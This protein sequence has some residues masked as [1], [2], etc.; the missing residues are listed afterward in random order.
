M[1]PDT[2]TTQRPRVTKESKE[3]QAAE[4]SH[5]CGQAEQNRREEQAVGLGQ[6][7]LLSA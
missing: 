1:T 3:S 2:E 4:N 6:R 7:I 5:F